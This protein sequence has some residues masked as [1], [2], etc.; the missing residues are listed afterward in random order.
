LRPGLPFVALGLTL[1]LSFLT[2]GPI[3]LLLPG[4]GILALIGL[5]R[6]ERP[7][8]PLWAWVASAGVFCAAGLGWFLATYLRLGWEPLTYFFLHE[9]L[10]R[11]A[12]ATYD[13]GHH[14]WF[15]G[16]VY[17]GEAMPWSLF[18]P[19][20][21]FRLLRGKAGFGTMLLCLWLALGVILLSISR[22]KLDYYLMPFY[23]VIS[24]LIGRFFVAIPWK[25]LETTWSR[26][27]LVMTTLLLGVLAVFVL[28]IPGPWQPGGFALAAVIGTLGA[29]SLACLGTAWRPRPIRVLVV[30]TLAIGLGLLTMEAVI[31]PAFCAGQPNR[32]VVATVVQEQQRRPD[33][34]VALRE[35]PTE[36]ERDLLFFARITL[37]NSDDLAQLA[38]SNRPYFLMVNEHDASRLRSI[39]GVRELRQYPYLSNGILTLRGATRKMQPA[40][41]V[42][43]ANFE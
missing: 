8:I 27:V 25:T 13:S 11:F 7:A 24:L 43:F 29:V 3:G 42:L 33:V 2:K 21:L 34:R 38:S 15:F 1:G 39:P 36:I 14:W 37:E 12:S 17:L 26:A 41:L 32:A 35:D 20:A 16:Q 40:A 18:F 5:K 4:L 10:Q 9:N 31:L 23:P 28:R 22:G 30:M 6:R 19:L